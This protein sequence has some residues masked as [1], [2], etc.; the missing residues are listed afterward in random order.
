M[1]LEWDYLF[2][3]WDTIRVGKNRLWEKWDSILKIQFGIASSREIAH[4]A[5]KCSDDLY[6]W[7][8]H[9]N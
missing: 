4:F 2:E 3:Y 6:T 7:R 1:N 9:M 5:S 8:V